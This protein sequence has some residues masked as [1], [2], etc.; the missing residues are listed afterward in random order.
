MSL[1][2]ACG[3]GLH[4]LFLDP[5]RRGEDGPHQQGPLLSVSAQGHPPTLATHT[6]TVSVCHSPPPRGAPGALFT[7]RGNCLEHQKLKNIHEGRE[8]WPSPKAGWAPPKPCGPAQSCQPRVLSPGKRL[9][10]ACSLPATSG[11]LGGPLHTHLGGNSRRKG[12][13]AAVC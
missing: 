13:E 2:R 7:L 9:P 11:P 5:G 6:P 3:S 10:V 4:S 8:G 12:P 1:W